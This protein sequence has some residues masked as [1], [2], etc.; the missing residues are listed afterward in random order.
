M[1][2]PKG[3][4]TK[5][6]PALA[7]VFPNDVTPNNNSKPTPATKA[8]NANGASTIVL[9]KLLPKN[10]YRASAYATGIEIPMHKIVDVID[11]IS[12]NFMANCI[13]LDKMLVINA[14]GVVCVITHMST[15]KM[16]E[17]RSKVRTIV[18]ILNL[19]FFT[20]LT[21]LSV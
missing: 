8:G 15:D 4:K 12:D 9:T 17:A 18:R 5:A 20:L 11:V 13:S 14:R 1:I 21:S 3:V 2:I 19:E 16:K 10:L 7:S 6:I